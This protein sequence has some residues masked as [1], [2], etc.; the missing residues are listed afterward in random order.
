MAT[1]TWSEQQTARALEIWA[2][3]QREHDVSGRIGQAVGIDP[4]TGGVWFG[5]SAVDIRRQM[6]SE[7]SVVPFYCVRVGQDYYLRKGGH[8]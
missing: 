7:G 3:Y 4:Q 2:R 1:S 5:Q 8:R 6:E